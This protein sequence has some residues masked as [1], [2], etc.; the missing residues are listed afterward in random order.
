MNFLFPLFYFLF[1]WHILW[2]SH[3]KYL[4]LWTPNLNIIK[5]K[6]DIS[7]EEE[8]FEI[9]LLCAINILN[10]YKESILLQYK[11]QCTMNW[12]SFSLSSAHKQEIEL[13][14]IP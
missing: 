9:F 2:W 10:Y 5:N 7:T 3:P 14:Q 1:L 4:K 12:E 13:E 11:D 8:T 6:D